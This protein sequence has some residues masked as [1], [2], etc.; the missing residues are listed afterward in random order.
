MG[1]TFGQTDGR[2]ATHN[3]APTEGHM[4]KQ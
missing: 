1:G 4:I 2:V 3:V